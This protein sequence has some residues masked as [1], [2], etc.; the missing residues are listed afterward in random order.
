MLLA[1]ASIVA[2]GLLAFSNGFNGQFFLDDTKVI[3]ENARLRH[4]LPQ[5]AAE[6]LGPRAT[7]DF[8]LA[9]N[10]ATGKLNPADY[11][12]GNLLMH[13]VAGL[14]LF[15][16]VRRTMALPGT[17][18][19]VRESALLIAWVTAL[20]WIVHPLAGAA[21][22]YVCQRYEL[23]AGL[24]TLLTL[25]AV[26]RGATGGFRSPT[27]YA[28]AVAACL[29]GMSCK[30]TMV[31]TPLLVLA[32]DRIFLSASWREVWAR[33]RFLH[34]G[35]AS[36]I[37][38]LA[39]PM[40]FPQ[41]TA[42]VHDYQP[43]GLSLAYLAAQARV[44]SQY[45]RQVAWP[46]PLCIDYGWSSTPAS[47]G[48]PWAAL[49]ALLLVVATVSLFARSKPRLGF[50]GLGFLLLL[51]PT[52]SVFP[53][54]DLAFDHRMYLPL[55]AF[56]VVWALLFA[57]LVR[58]LASPVAQSIGFA[59]PA[60]AVAAALGAATHV[61]NRDYQDAVQMWSA[62][63]Q[64]RPDNT[65]AAVCL[66]GE[67]Y[68]RHR[69]QDV[70]AITERV[71]AQVAPMDA[72]VPSDPRRIVDV[73]KLLNN[74]GLSQLRESRGTEAVTTLRRAVTLAPGNTLARLGLASAALVTG[75]TNTAL[76]EVNTAYGLAPRNPD[77]IQV[78]ADLLAIT[79]SPREAVALYRQALALF[80]DRL[81]AQCRLAWLLATCPDAA[82][83]DGTE[84]LRLAYAFVNN[85]NAGP[86]TETFE[87]LAA[88]LAESGD[89]ARAAQIQA[90]IV[91]RLG[92]TP[93]RQARLESYRAGQPWRDSRLAT[94][95][96]TT[97][98]D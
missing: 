26:L 75:D 54:P 47:F 2:A 93:A 22:Q 37:L 40:A 45:L 58:K 41:L 24:C 76:R 79:G 13:L 33:R 88:A 16:L 28:A 53:H 64:I 63:L 84:A 55:A 27:W 12:A 85:G 98:R 44:V 38:Y 48:G 74:L 17:P 69:D 43:E 50:L 68:D 4:V 92:T 6:W 9:M 78:K 72:P 66:T 86:E 51:A 42:G 35:L 95:R 59:L 91:D 8:T 19:G 32:F 46:H 31:V 20:T 81:S 82:I 18:S 73:S 10:Y 56:A 29:V 3:V 57:F 83:R 80:P 87:T 94:D 65:R 96:H 89:P 21:V 23:M 71:L 14:V 30:E 90:Q 5:S 60:L 15:G 7:V 97:K 39:L 67:L 25:Y 49:P 1:M 77:V 70:M 34:V 36:T 62:V 11:H 52:S 61:R